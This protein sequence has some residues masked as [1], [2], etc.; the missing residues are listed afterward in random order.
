MD[1]QQECG[2][3]EWSEEMAKKWKKKRTVIIIRE[4][5]CSSRSWPLNQSIPTYLPRHFLQGLCVKGKYCNQFLLLLLLLFLPLS[6]SLSTYPFT[7][8]VPV[9][10]SF[11]SFPAASWV[12]TTTWSS[13]VPLVAPGWRKRKAPASGLVWITKT[14]FKV[15]TEDEIDFA[16]AST[17]LELSPAS[18]TENSEV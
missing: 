9:S 10:P 13:G 12:L 14:F 8:K 17:S 7:N 1:R 5:R 2:K 11:A 15:G 4:G 6:L 18:W 16:S 3:K